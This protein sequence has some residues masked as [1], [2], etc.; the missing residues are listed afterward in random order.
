VIYEIVEDK[1]LLVQLEL[2][3]SICRQMGISRL[4]GGF[5]SFLRLVVL[6]VSI[7]V[8]SCLG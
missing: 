7:V 1:K 3:I 4:F 2:R 8:M 5:W 6:A